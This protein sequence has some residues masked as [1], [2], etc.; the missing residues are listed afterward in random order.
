MATRAENAVPVAVR[1]HWART[2]AKWTGIGLLSLLL[3]VGALV[4]WLNTDPG[5]RFIVRQINA[6]EAASGLQVRVGDIEGSIF[7][8]LTLLD[9]TV[10]DPRGVFFRAPRAELEYRP[11]SYVRNHIDIR[12][13]VIPE[14]RLHRVP[15]L[16]PGD[17]DA[18]LLPDIDIDIGRL[19]IGRLLVDPAVTGQRHIL[20]IDSRAKISDGRAEVGL[21]L[22]AL[23]APGVAGGDRL[24]LRLDAVPAE[25]RLDLALGMRGPA[26]GFIAGLIGIDRPIAAHVEGRGDWANWRGRARAAVS[27]QRFADLALSARDGTFSVQ[28]PLR[29]GLFISGPV[30]RLAGPQALVS[31]VTTVENRR[32]D[33]R[34]RMSSAALAVA[35]EGLVDLGRNRYENLRVATRLIQP[36]TIAPNLSGRDVRLAMILNGDFAT[37]SVAYDLR[38]ARL[39]FDTT[40]IEGLHA[41][42]AARVRA[43]DIIVPVSARA[44]RI[45][46]FDALAGGP[47]ANVRL[48]GQLGLAGT[49]LVSDNLRLR[50][51]RIDATLALAF[52]FSTGRYLA[53]IQGRV[54]NYLVD[55]VGLIDLTT[56]LDLVGEAGGFGLRGRIAARTRR[57]DNATIA[58]LLGGPAT[59]SA[60]VAVEASG[61]VRVDNVRLAAPLLRVT[62]GSGVYRSDG[63]IDFTLAGVSESYGPLTVRVTGTPGAPQVLL[64]AAN[65]GFGVGLRNVEASVR[66]TGQG[67]A[68]QASGESDYGPFT[69]DVM[70]RSGRGPMTIDINR[71]TFAGV[72]FQGRVVQ[73]RAGPY[74]GTLTMAG[75]GLNGSVRLSAAGRYQ[76]I[77]LAATANGARTPGEVPI[78]I[79]RGLVRATIILTPTPSIVADAQLAGLSSGNLFVERAR[80]RINYQGGNGTAQLFAEGRRGVSFRVAA[81]SVLAPDLIRAALQ[82]Q[83]NNI[84]FR[85]AQPAEIR[86]EAGSWRLLPVRVALRQGEQIRLAGRWGDGLIIQSRL[87]GVDLSI[88]N[89]FWPD[90]GIGGRATGSLDFAQPADGSFPRAE[91]RLNFADFTRTGIAARSVPVNMAL[92]GSLRPEGG[93]LAAVI[94]RGAGVIG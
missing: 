2:T 65:P 47:V 68:L 11:F 10:A 38:A 23:A 46:G 61:L 15:E 81:N 84:P 92:A 4:V 28:G 90:L 74:V 63:T 19:R 49:R 78:L 87:D 8:D 86:R 1:R 33:L 83:V 40:T 71:L 27:G 70:I 16:R 50:S 9:V 59:L 39:T 57:I 22:D 51:D 69:A 6:F 52:D 60:N 73:S 56:D 31:L 36:G 12:S 20:S 25:N 53:G 41:V 44:R 30:E 80:A 42:G 55:G 5:R 24:V 48:D 21:A 54:N 18:P 64:Q 94:R 66:A 91:A 3:L 17:P 34:L 29:P 26:N 85:F 77:D 14:A 7:G 72:D 79:Q 43:D 37:P 88:L 58:E 93:Q 13:M 75:Q 45:L 76:Q 67:W 89:A 35:A 62:S 82:G 32:A